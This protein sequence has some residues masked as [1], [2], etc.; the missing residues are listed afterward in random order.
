MSKRI[1]QDKK[2][3]QTQEKQHTGRR[4]P[5]VPLASAAIVVGVIIAMGMLLLQRESE[6]L[7]RA[8]ELSL[9]LPTKLFYET[10]CIYP[11]GTLTWLSAFM[12]QFFFHP[13]TG[14]V[15]LTLAWLLISALTCWLFRLRG[16]WIAFSVLVPIALM[17]ALTQ[18]GY[19]LY[20]MKLQGHLW[21]PTMATLAALVLLIPST[22]IKGWWRA[23]YMGL[24]GIAAYPLMGAWGALPLVLMAIRHYPDCHKSQR[25]TYLGIA[26]AC[27][28]LMP[29]IYCQWAYPQVEMGINSYL[30]AMPSYQYGKANCTEFHYPYYALALAFI[31]P[32]ISQWLKKKNDKLTFALALVLICLGLFL[33]EKR[34]YRDTNFHKE[35]KMANCIERLDWEGVLSTMRDNTMG[36]PM[37]PTRMMVMEKNLALFRLGRAGDEMFRYPEGAE[38]YCVCGRHTTTQV[39]EDKEINVHLPIDGNYTHEAASTRI[40]QIGGKMIYYMLGKEQFCYRWCMEDG[41]EFGWNVNVLKYMTKASLVTKDWEVARKFLNLLKKTRYHK[42]WVERYEKFLYRQDLMEEDE[43]FIPILP[44]SRFPDRLDG[45]MTLVEMYLL[46]TFSSGHGADKYYQEMTLMCALIM[47]DINLFWPRFKQYVNMHQSDP[48][49]RVPTHYQE[50]AYLYSVLEPQR[51]SIMWP[52]MTNEQ[53]AQRIPFDE[54]IKKR[55][56]DF[57]NF[58]TQCGSMTEEQKKRAFFP[59]FGDTFYYFYFLV[60]NQKTN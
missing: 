28:A 9:F 3:E 26:A 10:S 4:L 27:M 57:I 40:T 49:F 43:E 60:R 33:T 25:F 58:N 1:K 42:E 23:A 53:A 2:Q 22:Y 55:Y 35:V 44:M 36:D 54:N 14:V 59:Q 51:E 56:S 21:V 7:F 18:T 24:V 30:A 34:W 5:L 8:Q 16:P 52:G 15:L 11:G 13:L 38:Q 45:D 48:G 31:P 12:T 17:A 29:V 20:Y 41:V 47:K 19:W 39:K 6:V 46:K 50:A 32:V 37:P